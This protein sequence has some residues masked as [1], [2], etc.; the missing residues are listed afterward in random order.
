MLFSFSCGVT[1]APLRGVCLL[2][3]SREK[4]LILTGEEVPYATAVV[5][6]RWEEPVS[7][8]DAKG[9]AK[10][11]SPDAKLPVT[12]IAAAIYCER[13]GQKAILIGKQGAMLKAIGTAAR[14]EIESLLGTR[15]FLELFV[16]VQAEWRSSRGFVEELDWRRQLEEIAAKQAVEEL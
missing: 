4:I 3:T 5:V 8:L 1:L 11:R 7:R 9:K 2:Y 14:K 12:K 13:E 6:E 10:K 16:K 15:V